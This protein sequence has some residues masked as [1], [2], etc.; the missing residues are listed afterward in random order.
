MPYLMQTAT[1]KLIMDGS[2]EISSAEQ[3]GP[4]HTCTAQ[5]GPPASLVSKSYLCGH[6]V[7]RWIKD[8]CLRGDNRPRVTG[9]AVHPDR[10]SADL[11]LEDNHPPPQLHHQSPVHPPSLASIHC[12]NKLPLPLNLLIITNKIQ[13]LPVKC[14][15]SKLMH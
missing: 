14:K 13:I 8:C 9:R 11:V 4:D 1:N 10:P 5:V 3:T 6:M 2:C 12:Q 7:S 15:S